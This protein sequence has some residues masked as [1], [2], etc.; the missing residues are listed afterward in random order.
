MATILRKFPYFARK[1]LVSDIMPKLIERNHHATDL[2]SKRQDFTNNDGTFTGITFGPN[3]SDPDSWGELPNQW[4]DL[5][6]QSIHAAGPLLVY[7]VYSY[8]TPIAYAIG[9]GDLFMPDVAYSV[10]TSKHQGVA[11][12]SRGS[13]YAF[14]DWPPVTDTE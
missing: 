9:T 6:K 4:I 10:T 1:N 3:T 8:E 13:Q 5:I 2:I 12:L 11:R 7:I 14:L